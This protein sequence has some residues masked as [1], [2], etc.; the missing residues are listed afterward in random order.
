MTTLRNILGTR[1]LAEILSDREA[2]SHAMQASLDVA[3]DPWGVKVERVEMLDLHEI[4]CLHILKFKILFIEKMSAYHNSFN[5][6]WPP[7]LRPPGK[8][9]L[10]L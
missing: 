8:P 4:Y 2:I 10:K 7:K 1:N 5:E 9:E 6:R 3:T